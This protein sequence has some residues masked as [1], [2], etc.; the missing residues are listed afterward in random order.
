MVP[1]RGKI[2]KETMKHRFASYLLIPLALLAVFACQKAETVR[3]AISFAPV[4]A[5]ATKAIIGGTDYPT[6]ESFKVSAYHNASP[7][8]PGS[9][10][11]FQNL[12]AAKGSSYW[13]TSTAEYWPLGGRLD[14]H[15][16]S[17]ASAGLTISS[18][19]VSAT[20][21]SI[22]TPEQMTTDLC[23]ASATVADCA[24]HPDAVPLAF[25]HALSQVVFRVKAADYY[26]SLT[27]TISL[28]LNSLSMEGIYSVGDFSNGTWSNHSGAHTYNISSATTALTYDGDDEPETI[29]LGAF[30]LIPQELG[31]NAALSVGFRIVQRI[32][33]TDYVLDNAPVTIPLG[34]TV[35]EWLPGK[36]YIY[37]ISIGMNNVITFT[38]S[39]VGWQDEND[40]IIVEEN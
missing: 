5:K 26:S 3:H 35:D 28:S 13:E 37:T 11:Y 32:S 38:A 40:N 19:G 27:N 12:T 7:A 17:P 16:F 14:F 18:G 4:T 31:A 34:D 39:T 2:E 9:A 36:K 29:D 10:M 21:Y 8:S 22:T 25:H 30:V 15:S 23:Y 1:V 33:G 20:S 6:G 24:T